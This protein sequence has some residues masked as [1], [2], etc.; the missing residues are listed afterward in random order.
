M[1]R[2]PS[3]P[4]AVTGKVGTSRKRRSCVK[5]RNPTVTSLKPMTGYDQYP[6]CLWRPS[7]LRLLESPAELLIEP[8][9][10][11]QKLLRS[12]GFREVAHR[13]AC[14]AKRL[15]ELALQVSLTPFA[16]MGWFLIT[17]RTPSVV[18]IAGTCRPQISIKNSSPRF[19][20]RA[21]LT[22][23]GAGLY[24]PSRRPLD[25]AVRPATALPSDSASSR[26][27]PSRS[28]TVV[29]HNVRTGARLIR[30]CVRSRLSAYRIRVAGTQSPLYRI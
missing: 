9:S 3:E 29:A 4:A 18:L 26:S 16:S 12:E 30:I 20:A 1:L 28:A 5:S 19:R 10:V 25:C 8:E 2:R 6:T 7:R 17:A 27:N 11:F 14:S 22:S 15:A 21:F 23:C 24:M 13:R